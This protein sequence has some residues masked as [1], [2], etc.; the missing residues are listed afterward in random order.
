MDI[1]DTTTLKAAG[2]DE[3]LS[4]NSLLQKRENIFNLTQKAQEAVLCPKDYGAY[5]HELR[6]ALAARICLLNNDQI[7]ADHY[8]FNAGIYT[9]LIDPSNAGQDFDLEHVLNFIDKVA[10]RPRDVTEEDIRALQKAGIKDPDI[11][12]LAELNSFMAYQ[13]RLI[14]GLRLL[15]GFES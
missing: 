2:I 1:V 12:R 8:S 9:D 5:N 13:T 14:A 10:T 3:Y 6:H 7:A 15:K 11:V 4:D